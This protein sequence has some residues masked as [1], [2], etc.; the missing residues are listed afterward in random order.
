MAE[1]VVKDIEIHGG[2]NNWYIEVA[3]PPRSYRVDIGYRSRA[4]Q[5]FTLTRSNV[6]TTPRAG[7]SGADL[8]SSRSAV[9]RI[10]SSRSSM[11]CCRG[12]ISSCWDCA[13][14]RRAG[15]CAA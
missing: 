15:F 13:D 5:F 9:S 6:V 1:S 3:N 8:R 11:P 7:I 4:G 14:R 10:M 12:T 2:A